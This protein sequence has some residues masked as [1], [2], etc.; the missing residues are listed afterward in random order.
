MKSFFIILIAANIVIQTIINAFLSNDARNN[1]SPV[2]DSTVSLQ[3]GDALLS[4]ELMAVLLEINTKLDRQNTLLSNALTADKAVEYV[5][6]RAGKN[7]G[8]NANRYDQQT[9]ADMKYG[10]VM[11]MHKQDMNIASFLHD[12]RLKE[13]SELDRNEVMEELV[14]KIDSNEI[15]RSLFLPGYKR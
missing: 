10:L 14:R 12:P 11:D 3:S 5:A 9:L 1:I 4:A 8:A 2:K 13:L 6:D 7:T 15:D